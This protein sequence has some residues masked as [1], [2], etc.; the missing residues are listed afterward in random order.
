MRRPIVYREH[1]RYCEANSG[2][3]TEEEFRG[4]LQENDVQLCGTTD[5]FMVAPMHLGINEKLEASYYIGADWLVE[6][7]L[8]LVVLPKVEK[9]DFVQMLGA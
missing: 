3:M 8:A 6:K 7:Q 4:I 9:I 1:Q 5:G 2:T